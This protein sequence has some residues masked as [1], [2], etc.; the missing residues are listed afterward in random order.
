MVRSFGGVCFRLKNFRIENMEKLKCLNRNQL[1]YIALIAMLIDHIAWAFVDPQ[2]PLIGGIM[3][4]FGRITGGTMAF[5]VAEG[6][7]HTR[8]VKRYQIRL[9]LFA[10]ISWIPFV[11]FETGL[12]PI[13]F[14]EGEFYFYPLQSVIY[15]LFLGLLAIRVWD[16][17]KMPKAV[18]IILIVIICVFS[19]IGDW[20]F[21]NVLACL[22]LHVFKDKPKA[23]WL[24]FTL[25]YLIPNIGLFIWNGFGNNW[26][27][28]GVLLIPVIICLFYNG[29]KGSDNPIHKWSFYI[30]YP[31]HLLII[32]FIRWAV[33][34]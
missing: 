5:F 30:F 7:E 29:E 26:Y 13:G 20:A 27:Q 6:Y 19:V 2:S 14:Y 12:L 33:L 10:V 17:E 24:A 32:G 4:L 16:S 11:Y 28:L 23:K 22:F 1:K 21:M 9:L 34:I 18:R 15:T 31:L 3:H 25:S 8:S